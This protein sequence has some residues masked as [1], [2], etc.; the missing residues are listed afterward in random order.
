M[1]TSAVEY[2][3]ET[4]LRSRYSTRGIGIRLFVTCWLIYSVH[5]AT[6]TVREIYLALAIG[7]HFSF[8]VDE[9]AHMH[10]DL[11]EKPG[12]GWHHG[13]NPGASMVAALPYVLARPLIDP[14][15]ARVNTARRARPDSAIPEYQSPW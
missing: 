8:R 2:R 14:I 5:L 10:P 6:N 4:P 15:V 3:A 9:Y 7:D 11:F 12:F 1:P 13:A